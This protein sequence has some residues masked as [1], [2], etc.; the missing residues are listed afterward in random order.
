MGGTV[1]MAGIDTESGTG[2][3]DVSRDD[4]Y[5]NAALYWEVRFTDYITMT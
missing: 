2:N 1:F 3:A 5:V 4:F